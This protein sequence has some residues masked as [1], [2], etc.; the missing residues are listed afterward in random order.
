MYFG[1]A[2][3]ELLV[4]YGP[5]LLRLELA[6]V[7]GLVSENRIPDIAGTLLQIMLATS[8]AGIQWLQEA[9][10]A[11]PEACATMIDKQSF[12]QRVG[13]AC[14]VNPASPQEMEQ[15][16]WYRATFWSDH[17]STAACLES[18]LCSVAWHSGLIHVPDIVSTLNSH[19]SDYRSVNE[20]LWELSRT[21]RRTPRVRTLAEKALAPQELWP[22]LGLT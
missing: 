15:S 2:I 6:A 16:V 9:V 1:G 13:Q 12:V 20:A 11:I 18:L 17:D 19:A 22:D 3:Q 14:T 5:T 21:C 10:A 4:N 8:Q 7:V